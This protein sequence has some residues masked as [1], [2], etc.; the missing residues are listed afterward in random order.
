MTVLSEEE[1]EELKNWVKIVDAM[2]P[3]YVRS[4]TPVN[5]DLRILP[6]LQR[7][8]QENDSLGSEPD[9]YVNKRTVVSQADVIGGKVDRGISRESKR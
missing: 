3:G 5:V 9:P 4:N 8:T 1:R 2:Y 7:L 6:I